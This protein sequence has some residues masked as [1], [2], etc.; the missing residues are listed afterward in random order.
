MHL[1][2]LIHQNCDGATSS[3][4]CQLI[5]IPMDYENITIPAGVLQIRIEYTARRRM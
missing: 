4:H 3:P 5:N 1:N 2:D